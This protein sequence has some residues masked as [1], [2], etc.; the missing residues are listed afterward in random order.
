M[1]L[2]QS[3]KQLLANKYAFVIK[4]QL[5]HWNVAGPNF[6]E[7]HTFFGALY[8]EVWTSIDAVAEGI[9]TLDVYAPG[10]FQRFSELAT[11]TD[12][13]QI[14][15]AIAMLEEL[16]HDNQI[17]IDNLV[18]A[19]GLAGDHL[20]IQNLLQGRVEAHEKHAWM[21]RSMIQMNRG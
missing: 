2:E 1:T 3:L 7:Y 17:I 6:Y 21:L 12:Q 15:R 4:A 8:N 18:E 13:V 14:P 19:N 16:L 5:F 11:I 9:R 10:S 20:G